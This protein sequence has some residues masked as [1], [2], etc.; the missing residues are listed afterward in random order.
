M[1]VNQQPIKSTYRMDER[2][3]HADRPIIQYR[4]HR[5][6][7]ISQAGDS[8]QGKLKTIKFNTDL[9]SSNFSLISQ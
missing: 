2:L 4:Q 1:V 8:E 3:I 5:E 7:L 9:T 6:A